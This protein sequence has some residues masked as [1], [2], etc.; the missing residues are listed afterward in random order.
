MNYIAKYIVPRYELWEAT[1]NLEIPK[2]MRIG[3]NMYRTN[4]ERIPKTEIR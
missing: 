4:T 3:Q 1:Q 2:N